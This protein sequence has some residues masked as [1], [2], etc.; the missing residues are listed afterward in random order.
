MCYLHGLDLPADHNSMICQS[1]KCHHQVGCTRQNAQ[2]Y[3]SGGHQCC[4]KGMH[5]KYLPANPGGWQAWQVRTANYSKNKTSKFINTNSPIP[6]PIKTN[7]NQYAALICDDEDEED[8]DSTAQM[9]NCSGNLDMAPP[10]R[11]PILDV[12]VESTR[13]LAITAPT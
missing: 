1:P 3:I 11:P 12:V 8:E 7:V 13:R 6:T 10:E 5:K 2:T 9:W 4:K